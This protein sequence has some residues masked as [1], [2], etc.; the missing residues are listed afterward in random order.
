[1]N[2][3]PTFHRFAAMTMVLAAL[4]AW[5]PVLSQDKTVS[6]Q[7][8]RLVRLDDI[9]TRAPPY[10]KEGVVHVLAWKVMRG[11]DGRRGEACLVMKVLEK[12]DG[13]GRWCLACLS[14]NPADKEPQWALTFAH[15]LGEKGSKHFLGRWVLHAK[16]FKD[17]PGNKEIYDSFSIEEVN[18]SFELQ[19]GIGLVGCGVCE[20]SWKA[21]IGEEPTRFFSQ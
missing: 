21:V 7:I 6:N 17:R 10:G 9:P 14:R 20:E 18:W 8:S 12:D 11:A 13:Y 16:R 2:Q 1:M 5:S 19:A 4:T 3:F 15:L